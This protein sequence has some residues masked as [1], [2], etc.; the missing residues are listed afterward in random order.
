MASSSNS[1]TIERFQLPESFVLEKT[2]YNSAEYANLNKSK[3]KYQIINSGKLITFDSSLN[4]LSSQKI[5]QEGAAWAQDANGSIIGMTG[6]K[7]LAFGLDECKY[8]TNLTTGA[9]IL[10]AKDGNTFDPHELQIDKKG[11]FWFLS[12]PEIDCSVRTTLCTSFGVE[13]TRIFSDCQINATNSAGLPI[14]TW[15]ASEHI[16]PAMIVRSYAKEGPRKNYVDLFHCNSIDPVD[17][18]S[19]L[20]SSRNTNSIYLINTSTSKIIWKLG[21][22]SQK[23]VSLLTSGFKRKVGEETVA[24]HDARSLGN[25]LFSYYDNA[26]HTTNPAR[27]VLFKVLRTGKSQRAVMIKEF[28]NPEQINSLCTGS[29]RN[30]DLGNVIIGWGCSLD[31]MTLF[32]SSGDPI[33]SL[34]KVKTPETAQLFSDTPNILNGVDWA[35]AFTFAMSYRVIPTKTH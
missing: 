23:G 34:A 10:T 17:S 35:P 8:I 21:G 28:A 31:A 13:K 4:Y 24:Q 22:H 15:K 2:I 12:Y 26:S 11:N 3:A 1:K 30:S 27:G 7:N 14:F 29:M 6:C 5:P 19:V 25:N 33:V 16:S 9:I 18:T 32:N 20:L